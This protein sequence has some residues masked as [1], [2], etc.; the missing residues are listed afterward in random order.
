MKFPLRDEVVWMNQDNLPEMYLDNIWRPNLSITGA[1]DLPDYRK[2]GN[3]VRAQTTVRCSLRISP[4]MNSE[5]AKQ[6][7][8]KI[9]TTN[10]PY[11]A[12]T[13]VLGSNAGDGFCMKV[14]EPWL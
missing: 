7:L 4:V 1:G 14:L 6:K 13:T 10:V 8:I 2:A 9:L 12:K 5:E 11:N 3:V